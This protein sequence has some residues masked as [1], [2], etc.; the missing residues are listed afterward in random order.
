MMEIVRFFFYL[1]YKN[2]NAAKSKIS[3]NLQHAE[4]YR[5]ELTRNDTNNTTYILCCSSE[6]EKKS[7]MNELS[8]TICGEMRASDRMSTFPIMNVKHV[9]HDHHHEN[10]WENHH[11]HRADSS[12][13]PTDLVTIQDLRKST[14]DLQLSATRLS[15]MKNVILGW[16][17]HLTDNSSKEDLEESISALKSNVSKYRRVMED[18]GFTRHSLQLEK[19][20]NQ[21]I[22]EAQEKSITPQIKF[23]IQ[24]V[25]E[26]AEASLLDMQQQ[27]QQQMQQSVHQMQQSAQQTQLQQSV[28]PQFAQQ[29]QQQSIQQTQQQSVQQTQQQQFAQQTQ[30]MSNKINANSS[31]SRNSSFFIPIFESHE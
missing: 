2:R 14:A 8:Q 26:D 19:M 5:F 20:T 17:G 30:Q 16:L 13:S 23:A 3:S 18:Y 12:S 28:Q 21:Y 15:H 10:H 25:L 7:W 6:N 1:F 31:D 4:K 11:R 9:S 22:N 24:V 27:M 29:T